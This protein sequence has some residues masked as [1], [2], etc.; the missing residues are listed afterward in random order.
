[1]LGFLLHPSIP[2]LKGGA[3]ITD[4][5]TGTGAWM[6][7][8]ARE[9]EVQIRIDGL[10][11]NLAQAPLKQWLPPNVNLR[12]WNI[13]DDVPDDLVGQ[14]DIVHVHLLL[15]VVENENAGSVVRNTGKLLKPGG[16]LLWDELNYFGHRVAS[17]G[18]SVQT[19]AFEELHQ[20]MHA[21]G[22][23][24]WTLQ[25]DRLMSENGL[26]DAVIHQYEDGLG[27]A[28][29]CNDLLMA[30]LEEFAAGLARGGRERKAKW[31]RDRIHCGC[32]ESLE[33]AAMLVPKL[34]CVGRKRLGMVQAEGYMETS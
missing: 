20:F 26:E 19:S 23:F 17:V 30:T 27:H 7:G 6:L 16:Y 4:V 11:I 3:R 34:V 24:D 13:F 5:A 18:P 32:R 22:K 12:T 29:A 8:L 25:L 2:P 21:D 33:G 10:D 14:F 15:L 1:M 31:L 28:T 9:T